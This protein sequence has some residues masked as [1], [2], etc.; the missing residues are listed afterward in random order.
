MLPEHLLS[1]QSYLEMRL[2][3][4]EEGNL[5]PEGL[6][7]VL[8][9]VE[10]KHTSQGEVKV[11]RDGKLKMSRSPSVARLPTNPEQQRTRYK[12]MAHH[13]AGSWLA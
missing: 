9:Q 4:F 13:W 12:V 10:D 2:D 5:L 6:H 8:S 3:Q 1:G 7:E 11:I